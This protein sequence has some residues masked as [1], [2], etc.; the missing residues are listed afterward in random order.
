MEI[1]GL[2]TSVFVGAIIGLLGG[3]GSV[4]TIPM[5]VYLFNINPSEATTYSLFI[6]GAISGVGFI[7][8]KRD[9]N[10]D[11]AAIFQ[12]GIPSIIGVLISRR[13]ILPNIPE[14]IHLL[15]FEILKDNFLLFLFSILLLISAVKMI[16]KATVKAKCSTSI[17]KSSVSGLFVGSVTGLLGAGG[18]FLI[19]PFLVNALKIPMKS[20]VGTSLAII[21]LNSLLGFVAS[22]FSNQVL[23]W[24]LLSKVTLL[25]L[26]GFFIGNFYATK[27]QSHR[28][29]AIFGWFILAVGLSIIISKIF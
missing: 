6:V 29:K 27:I 10:V 3:G 13:F 5:L 15:E 22:D 25:A 28:L 16:L 11:I 23:N 1:F 14:E 2:F 24:M 7:K 19:I 12:F 17:F 4:L 26:L 18:G 8:S 20:A 21:M 9:K